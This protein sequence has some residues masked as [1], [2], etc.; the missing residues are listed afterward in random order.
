[1]SDLKWVELYCKRW[2]CETQEIITD[3]LVHDNMQQDIISLKQFL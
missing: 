2:L 1:M 3:W